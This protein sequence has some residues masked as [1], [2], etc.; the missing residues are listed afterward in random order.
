M[1]WE[2]VADSQDAYSY[3]SLHVLTPQAERVFVRATRASRPDLANECIGMAR[4][5]AVLTD[6]EQLIDT[7]ILELL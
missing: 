5:C 2:I 7:V 1:L 4:P 6:C 3:N